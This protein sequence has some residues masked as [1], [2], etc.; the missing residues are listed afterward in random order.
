VTDVRQVV[1]DR[2]GALLADRVVQHVYRL[3]DG[4]IDQMEVRDSLPNES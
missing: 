1:R 4:L 2:T 3:R